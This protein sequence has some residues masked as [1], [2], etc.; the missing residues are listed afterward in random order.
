MIL[1]SFRK[2][3]NTKTYSDYNKMFGNENL[4]FVVI[5]TPTKFHYRM[6]KDALQSSI[7]VFCEKPFCLH[8]SEGEELIGLAAGESLVNQVGYHNHFIGTFREMS[9]LV[10]NNVIGELVHFTGEAYGPVV[11]KE[12]NSTWRSKPSCRMRRS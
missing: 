8:T 7:N 4:D 6:V 10:Q 12:K 5:A 1:E 2:Y 3:T 11:T 9:R